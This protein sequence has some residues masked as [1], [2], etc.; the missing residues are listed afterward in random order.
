MSAR[1]Q[2]LADSETTSLRQQGGKIVK[3]LREI[4]GY[5]QTDF[6][7]HAGS[8]KVFVSMVET[9]RSRI[10]PSE[11]AA[12]AVALRS[13]PRDFAKMMMRYYDPQTFAL[14]FGDEAEEL[15]QKLQAT[16]D[17]RVDE[18]PKR[19][20]RAAR[21]TASPEP[22]TALQGQVAGLAEQ[23]QMLARQ[24][25]ALTRLGTP[26]VPA[27]PSIPPAADGAGLPEG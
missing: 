1:P 18:F 27:K 8:T 13:E 9:G 22:M 5:S 7:L 26:P 11:V 2:K 25:E 20:R 14:L 24:V 21:E 16:L 6:A 3:Q 10:P 12:W 19:G 23:V 4:I 17:A 15:Q